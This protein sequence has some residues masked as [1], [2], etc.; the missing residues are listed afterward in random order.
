MYYQMSDEDPLMGEYDD[1]IGSYSSIVDSDYCKEIMKEFDYFHDLGATFCGDRQFPEGLAGR[2][3]YALDLNYMG[4]VTMGTDYSEILNAKLRDC[5]EEYRRVYPTLRRRSYFSTSQKVQKTPAGGG[6][7]VWHSEDGP[8]TNSCRIAVWMLYLN[9]DYKGGE[10]EFLYY[11][12]RVQPERGKL[13]IWPAGYTHAHKGNMV[14]EGMKY[15]I[16]GWFNNGDP[17]NGEQ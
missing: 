12:K 1:F 6:Y 9:D 5:F 4:N 8:G 2:F 11:Q 14:N 3:D 17:Y 15:V 16:T 10:T 13:I 7:H